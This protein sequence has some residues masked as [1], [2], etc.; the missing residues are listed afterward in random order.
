MR[1]RKHAIRWGLLILTCLAVVGC[2]STGAPDNWLAVAEDAPRDP[3]GSWVTVEYEKWHDEQFL[4]GEFLAVD[5][6]SL[7]VLT[8]FA[9]TGDPVVGVSLGLVKKAKIASFD[10]QTGKASGWVLAGTLSS[11]SHG[12][13][14]AISIPLWIIMG[15][16]MAGSQSR[17]PLENYPNLSWD[18]LTMYARF[19]QGPPPGIHQLD[20]RPKNQMMPTSSPARSTRD[21]VF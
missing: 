20:L 1:V 10:P 18:V 15:S 8:S 7:Y 2:A 6:D 11:L 16:A 21:T 19:P 3:Y 14:A 9:G 13:G 17:T 4:A 5:S 12:L